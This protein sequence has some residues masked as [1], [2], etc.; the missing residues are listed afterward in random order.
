MRI[1]NA[2]SVRRFTYVQNV[3]TLFDLIVKEDRAEF[4]AKG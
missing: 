1:K 4:E 3:P 2:K